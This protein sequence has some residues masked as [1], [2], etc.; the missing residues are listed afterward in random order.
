MWTSIVLLAL[1]PSAFA[2]NQIWMSRAEALQCPKTGPL[3][4]VMLDDANGTITPMV[5]DMDDTS[6]VL[7]LAVALVYLRL[8]GPPDSHV[9]PQPP[10]PGAQARV[11]YRDKVVSICDTVSNTI[12]T[13]PD[14]VGRNPL[15]YILAADIINLAQVNPTVHT[16][17]S[18]WIAG[19]L[20]TARNLH[21]TRP[22]NVGLFAGSSRVAADIYINDATGDE[23]AAW[24][25][26]RRW[27]GEGTSP[28]TQ[29]QWG[30]SEDFFAWQAEAWPLFSGI[31]RIDTMAPDCN[32]VMRD[33]DGVLPDDQRRGDCSSCGWNCSTPVAGCPPAFNSCKF[34]WQPV[35]TNY[36]Y[37]GLQGALAQ[38]VI[39]FR[40][41][42]DP[43]TIPDA[44]NAIRRAYVWLRDVAAHP[45]NDP[46][47]GPND[48]WQAY[49]ANRLYPGLALFEDLTTAVDPGFQVGYADWT[50]RCT[51]WP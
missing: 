42:R 19:W 34:T 1:A 13:D 39:H 32:G 44:T 20:P 21:N 16:K 50:T 45:V 23:L 28:Y 11:Y 5:N 17:F 48:L 30:G 47:N 36:A 9:L 33:V 26:F 46:V 51:T 37:T 4:A 40:R 7:T 24:E 22:N 35:K 27:L 18:N 8:P 3:W 38:A 12:P 10:I 15:G 31:N 25:I 6:D 2:Q 14:A 43:W 29:T 41:G 49:I